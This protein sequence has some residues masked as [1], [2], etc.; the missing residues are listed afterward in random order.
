MINLPRYILSEIASRMRR[1]APAVS[2]GILGGK[3][4]AV[5]IYYAMRNSDNS[6][7][8]F[9]FDPEQLLF[10]T[11]DLRRQG[12]KALGIAGSL[13]SFPAG[14]PKETPALGS[15]GFYL[16]VS[17]SDDEPRVKAVHKNALRRNA[18]H[19]NAKD[20]F[21]EVPASISEEE[22]P[23]LLR[24][25]QSVVEDVRG[26]RSRVGS[27]LKGA[28]D[29]TR[30]RAYRVPM[31]FYEQRKAETFMARVRIAAGVVNA[32]QLRTL[33]EGS[34]RFGNGKLHIT[35][36]QD[37]Q[38]HDIQMENA[39][40][41]VDLLLQ[42]GLVCRGGGGN[43]VR[44]VTADPFAGV[45][46]EEPFD[47]TPYALLA[48]EYLIKSRSSFNLPR[49]FKVA[50]SAGESDRALTLV[51]DV[52]LI[53]RIKNGKRGFEVYA[54]GGMGAHSALSVPV[55][56]FLPA[57]NLCH[58]IEA[59]KRV[60]D[61][62]GDRKNRRSARLR[63]VVERQ[64]VETFRL[65]IQREFENVLKEGIE[66]EEPRLFRV[67]D[68]TGDRNAEL[69]AGVLQQKTPGLYSIMLHP[70]LGDIDNAVADSL[71]Q[72]MESNHLHLRTTRTQGFILRDVR[73][74]DLN[75][76]LAALEEL[77]IPLVSTTPA[78]RPVA[79][80]GAATCKLGLC[81]SRNLADEIVKELRS[82]DEK[83]L[84]P[85]MYISGCPNACGQ[86]PIGELSFSG[87]ATRHGD[88]LMPY[89]KIWVSS[90]RGKSRSLATDVGAIPARSVPAFVSNLNSE[91][92]KRGDGKDTFAS[93][94]ET[95]DYALIKSVLA[96]YDSVPAYDEKPEYYRDL[97]KDE[98]FSL[99]GRGPGECG[100]GVLDVIQL[101]IQQAKSFMK[102]Y[103]ASK[104]EQ[105]LYDAALSTMRSLLILRGVDSKKDRE[106]MEA[107]RTH[108]ID[109]GWVKPEARQ[110][111]D[112]MI[113]FK[114]G[115][116]DSI[117]DLSEVIEALIDRVAGLYDS[118]DS[119]L[120]FAVEP[121]SDTPSSAKDQSGTKSG[122][123][124]GA[125]IDLRGVACPMNYVKAKLGLEKIPVGEILEIILDEGEPIRNVPA[126]FS[127]DGQEVIDIKPYDSAHF[128]VRVRRTE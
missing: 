73:G 88:H 31:G 7:E 68:L 24:L 117:G 93:I 42:V 127:A 71:A 19:R 32:A 116:V 77:P 53:A 35:T 22:D 55:Y 126:S 80:A 107:F 60:F 76:V 124:S 90:R 99:S 51:A 45:D 79:C 70:P 72:I 40:D 86:H 85:Q 21:V 62:Y 37:I 23:S 18:V 58:M 119:G 4:D 109:Q 67:L 110:V 83:I 9:S 104:D 69:P 96:R 63:Y 112:R 25:P 3:K 13:P 89:Y 57:N 97:G 64:G 11:S 74:Q 2:C 115:D 108:F 41:L 59:I 128:T 20:S 65:V 98:D 66:S 26:F 123:K 84:L 44:N 49:K 56:D 28:E 52:G 82:A 125:K 6:E 87:Q 78:S 61:R 1:D 92:G 43:T 102:D 12:F 122:T 91:L 114:L 118:L 46:E 38:I 120:S 30:F 27:Y 39:P 100:A 113:D 103:S 75:A 101:D 48:T 106:I 16:A 54:G 34:R 36:R 8:Q 17:L 81:L 15:R 94:A 33:A 5:S 121:Y 105:R 29:S 50:F 10:V 14:L 111:I 95:N 47:V